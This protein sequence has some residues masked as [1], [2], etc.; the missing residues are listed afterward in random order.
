[1]A[2]ELE[3]SSLNNFSGNI[4]MFDDSSLLIENKTSPGTFQTSTSHNEYKVDL[5]IPP[6]W[7]GKGG[8]RSF[9]LRS[10]SGETFR[11][12]RAAFEEMIISGKYQDAEINAMRDSLI[13]EGWE[14]STDI[15]DGWKIKKRT[16]D[17]LYAINSMEASSRKSV[18]IKRHLNN[19]QICSVFWL[20]TLALANDK[21]GLISHI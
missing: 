12:R 3:E 20:M 16:S 10:P 7:S 14:D 8:G 9:F 21:S 19:S 17:T 2:L 5:T 11:S 6:G 18:V 1:M 13:H 15:P 4:E